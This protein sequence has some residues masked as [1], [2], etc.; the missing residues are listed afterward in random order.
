MS[1]RQSKSSG[2]K[3]EK[4][5][6]V[7]ERRL[8]SFKPFVFVKLKCDG[9]VWP[10]ARSGH[11]I[12]CNK[13]NIYSYGGYNPDLMTTVSDFNLDENWAESKPLFR[14]VWKFNMARSEWSKVR[15]SNIPYVLASNAVV[16]QGNVLMVYGGTGVPFGQHCSHTLYVCNLS[17]E[18]PHF[19]EVMVKG[20]IPE[21]Q[22]GQA[23]F[24]YKQYFYVIGGT[25][26]YDYSCDVHRLDLVTGKWEVMRLNRGAP[27]DPPGRY[28]HEIGLYLSKNK[29]FI[30]GGGT[31]H[32][33]YELQDV[34]VYDLDTNKWSIHTTVGD[35]KVLENNGYPIARRF[36]SL[37]QLPDSDDVYVTGGESGGS[38][39]HCDTWKLNLESLQWTRI[40]S[41]RLENGKYFHAATLSPQGKM[42]LFGG[43]SQDKRSDELFTAWICIPKLQEICWEALNHYNIL[44]GLPQDSLKQM[45][46]PEFIQRLD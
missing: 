32:H 23:V 43:I 9:N 15:A 30:L 19:R 7:R 8:Y 34:P 35:A 4:R 42:Y 18:I 11:R 39:V 6:S 38:G 29:V 10:K 14:E 21:P 13:N 3:V 26:G 16:L 2:K 45:I 36:H 40:D 12:V 46:P 33:S 25:T 31:A 5:N 37:V 1:N 44:N 27:Y 17:D 22:Y 20:D 41:M 28:R 24:L